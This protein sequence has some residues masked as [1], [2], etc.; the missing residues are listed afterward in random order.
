MTE[1]TVGPGGDYPT[2]TALFR[3]V[4]PG[5]VV[6]VLTGTYRELLICKTPGVTWRAAEGHA[7]MIDGGWDNRPVDGY[8]NQVSIVADDVTVAG[9]K[10]INSPGRGIGISANR[11]TVR[12]CWFENCYH[13]GLSANGT[14]APGRFISGLTIENN[15]FVKLSQSWFVETRPQ[16]VAG[17]F[18]FVRVKDS[19]VK[20]NTIADGNGEGLN[21]DKDSDNCLYEGNTIISTNHAG[22]YFNR[23]TNCTVRGNTFIHTREEQYRGARGAFPAAVVFGD[24]TA[25]DSFG[26]Q[27][28]NEFSGNVVVSWGRLLEV[29]NGNNY[30]TLLTDTL[31]AGNTFIAGPETTEGIVIAAHRSGP[32]DCEFR[33]NVIWFEAAKV[34]AP[35]GS[36]AAGVRFQYNA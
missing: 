27:S 29:R 3:V 31:I 33:D 20:G 15:T 14:A 30:D 22:C 1:Y 8:I 21:I 19:T 10:V 4:K 26:P 36:I 16:N 7:P 25:A 35:I 24:E 12:G 2:L 9:L 5:D 32:H 13:G 17:S 18:I 28:G 6:N 34:S 11:A 23:P